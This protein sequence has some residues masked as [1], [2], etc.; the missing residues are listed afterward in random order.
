MDIPNSTDSNYVPHEIP[1][2]GYLFTSKDS[3]LKV[4]E[5]KPYT[6]KKHFTILSNIIN[7][8]YS[9]ELERAL[10]SI[11]RAGEPKNRTN[12]VLA[13]AGA[14]ITSICLALFYDLGITGSRIDS[15]MYS[16]GDLYKKYFKNRNP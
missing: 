6:T 10:D 8:R 4:K 1:S 5:P 2:G 3:T 16:F 12:L 7:D 15:L 13:S 14:G 11:E 9:T